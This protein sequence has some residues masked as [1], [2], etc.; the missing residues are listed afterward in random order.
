MS[1]IITIKKRKS[2]NQSEDIIK[3]FIPS[4]MRPNLQDYREII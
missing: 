3:C 1:K 2:V 4:N